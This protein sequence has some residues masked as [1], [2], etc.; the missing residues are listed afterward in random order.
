[1]NEHG[2]G[3]ACLKEVLLVLVFGI[4]ETVAWLV[5]AV[6]VAGEKDTGCD[7]GTLAMNPV[8]ALAVDEA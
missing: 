7:G 3:R 1:M 4:L 2:F 6:A 8:P 5:V